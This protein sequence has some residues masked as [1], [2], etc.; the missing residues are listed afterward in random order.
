MV[1]RVFAVL[2]VVQA[3]AMVVPPVTWPLWMLRYAAIESCLAAVVFGAI[4]LW[5]PGP[6]R[7]I[8]AAGLVIGLV[9]IV[10]SVPLFISEEIHFSPMAWLTGGAVPEVEAE[11]DVTVGGVPVDVWRSPGKARDA[12]VV[13]VHGGS[14]RQGE[15]GE[16]PH[17][18]AVLAEAG[19]TVFDVRYRLAPFP[20]GV[21]DVRCVLASVA[22]DPRI[23]PGRIAVLGRSAGG[24]IGLIAAY[25]DL[26]STCGAV[27]VAAVVALYPPTDLAWAHDHPYLPDVIDGV[28]ATEQYLGGAPAAVPDA[29]RRATPQTWVNART[30]PTLLLH[31]EAERCVRPENSTTLK[32][33]LDA[34]GVTCRLVLVPSAEHGFDVRR[35]GFGEQLAREE[36]LRFLAAHV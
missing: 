35:G 1:P 36:I 17:M 30:P 18:S 19:Y 23:N 4:G 27:S 13:V 2:A 9:P 16:V 6:W 31:G 14:W 20:A 24:E 22:Q 8:A 3:L 25:S 12:A 26:P 5:A 28:A 21:E 33:A 7:W 10:R 32:A 15:K 11:H 34:A 29:Y